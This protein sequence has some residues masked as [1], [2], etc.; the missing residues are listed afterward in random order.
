MSFWAKEE[1]AG[2]LF[3]ISEIVE[4]WELLREL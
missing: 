3:W 4:V 2:R 1:A